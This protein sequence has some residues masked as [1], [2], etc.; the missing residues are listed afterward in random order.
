MNDHAPLKQWWTAAEIASAAL[1]GLP[2]RKNRVNE[3]AEAED[4]RGKGGMARKRAGKGGG[5]EYHWHLFPKPTQTHLQKKASPAPTSAA[6]DPVL[7]A[8]QW[9][10]FEMSRRTEKDKAA[11]RLAII[12]EV[13]RLEATLGRQAAKELVADHEGIT[14]RS[15]ELYLDLVRGV[16]PNHR[17]AYLV[18]SKPGQYARETSV[19]PE[20]MD[21][22]KS[23]YLRPSEPALTAAHRRSTALAALQGIPAASERA[24]RR[25]Y[26]RTKS[27]LVETYARKGA[28]AASECY[29]PQIRDR[30]ALRALELGN[31]DFHRVDVFVKFDLVPGETERR[32][33]RP[34]IC[35]IQDS[36]SGML[37]GYSISQEPNAETVLKTIASTVRKYGIFEEMHFDNGREYAAKEV[38]GKAANR[39]RGKTRDDDYEGAL[40]RL[41]CKVTFVKPYSGRSKPIERFWRDV[42]SDLSKHPAFEG[43][44]TG[45][46]PSNKPSNYG[47]RTVDEAVFRRVAADVLH[48]LNT[49]T[50]RRGDG[51]DGR[52]FAQV[53]EESYAKAPIRKATEEQIREILLRTVRVKAGPDGR[54]R[55]LGNFYAH[56][57]TRELAGQHLIARYDA[58]DLMGGLHLYDLDDIALGH[59]ECQQKTGYTDVVSAKRDQKRRKEV[60][61]LDRKRAELERRFDPERLAEMHLQAPS[62]AEP[63]P[64]AT[65]IEGMFK[66]GAARRVPDRPVHGPAE[67]AAVI[68]DLEAQRE[69]KAKERFEISLVDIEAAVRI[70][71]DIDAGRLVT[72]EE[73]A[74]FEALRSTPE[75]FRHLL[76]GKTLTL[77]T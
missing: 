43:A 2:S 32:I 9:R 55:F 14:T 35:G 3:L 22:V 8:E 36:H 68:A 65:V 6:T 44:Y 33:G 75:Y 41:G 15:I 21:L 17:L 1:P 30:A 7:P 56:P 19:Q 26:K 49:R 10:R 29:P 13:E 45:N 20:F 76:R 4:W 53:F 62:A 71:A 57:W 37:L 73:A 51:M 11:W 60:K 23:D 67:H 50:G 24:T 61:A 77:G 42:A 31:S 27:H 39:F 5:W 70:G 69:K 74:L 34:Q 28:K 52:S 72:D 48:E 46:S 38:S 59:V 66:R 58:D 47:T 16:L 63:A 40:A 12:A 54:I 25:A 64:K 18:P